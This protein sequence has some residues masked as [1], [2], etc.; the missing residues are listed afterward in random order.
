[1]LHEESM[2]PALKT[3]YPWLKRLAIVLGLSILIWQ[4]HL[5]LAETDFAEAFRL[6]RVIPR[7]MLAVNALLGHATISL[8]ALY[9][10]VWFRYNPSGIR[11]RHVFVTAWIASAVNNIACM[12][13]LGGA[14]SRAVFYKRAGLADREVVRLNIMLFPSFFSGLGAL[15][16]F[17]FIG[18]RYVKALRGSYPGIYV[19]ITVFALYLLLYLLSE[20]IPFARL[21]AV[22]VKWGFVGSLRLKLGMV[23]VSTLNWLSIS[24]LLWFI[25]IQFNPSLELVAVILFFTLATCIGVVSPMPAGIGYFDIIMM[26]GLQM[27]GM[28]GEESINTV[29]MFRVSFHLLPFVTAMILSALAL[30]LQKRNA[31]LQE[32]GGAPRIL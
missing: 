21:R 12:G 7:H 6:L 27:A 32:S 3:W 19:V 2:A 25:G 23:A 31:D 13:G 16:W 15:M 17:N 26:A 1:M 22:L 20:M 30:R 28:S 10:F 24:A 11:P 18:A 5:V 8:V 14:V 29:L 9:D 4:G